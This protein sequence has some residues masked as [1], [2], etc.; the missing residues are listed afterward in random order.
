MQYKR[1]NLPEVSRKYKYATNQ[2]I[3]FKNSSSFAYNFHI[4][5]SISS[6]THY[7]NLI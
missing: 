5:I 7:L 1:D 2:F 6:H 4:N 3:S